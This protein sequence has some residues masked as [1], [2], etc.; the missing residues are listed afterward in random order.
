MEPLHRGKEAV[1]NLG[2]VLFDSVMGVGETLEAATAFSRLPW[3][4]IPR[5]HRAM[6][7]SGVG[8]GVEF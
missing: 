8:F 3:T 2:S 7:G 5:L 6:A 4:R 1:Q